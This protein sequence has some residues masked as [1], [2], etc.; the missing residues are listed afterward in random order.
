MTD[1]REVRTTQHEQ[2]QEQRVATFKA[3][4]MIW[5]LL[6]ILEALI[7]LRVIFKLIAVNAANPVAA[8]LYSVTNLFVAPFASLAKAPAAAGMVLEV[9]SI[10]AMIV[11]F[12]IAWG[13]E[14]IV[15]VVFY[16]PG[17]AVSVR[18]TTVA[19]HTPL[20]APSSV[21]QTTTTDRTTTQAPAGASQTTVTDRTNT[22]TPGSL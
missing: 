22:Q 10:I 5:L 2:G 20:Q 1:Y 12:L 7:A 6:G 14:R 3:T 15:N 19:E 21:S 18:Q 8:L 17:G 13:I 11:Y 4:Q 16:R 9:S